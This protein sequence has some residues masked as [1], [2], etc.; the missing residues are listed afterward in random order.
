MSRA[1]RGL[2]WTPGKEE[3]VFLLVEAVVLV[4]GLVVCR[5]YTG[6]DQV[7][8]RA[9]YDVVAGLGPA[10]AWRY[11]LM[12]VS[13]AEPVH[14]LVSVV[15]SNL[16]IDK[17]LWFSLFNC[18][19]AVLMMRLLRAW[20]F[21]LWLAVVLVLTNYYVLVLYFPAERLKFGFLF[22]TV[23]LFPG[24][25]PGWRVALVA[26][27]VLSHLSMLVPVSSIWLVSA[28]RALLAKDERRRRLL[29]V[30]IPALLG[31][32]F[33]L[34]ESDYIFWKLKTYIVD[35]EFDNSWSRFLPIAVM[36]ALSV[37][38]ARDWVQPALMFAPLVGGIAL[39]GG[40][41]LNMFVFFTYLYFARGPRAASDPVLLLLFVYMA[42]KSI[43]FLSNVGAY[44]SGFQ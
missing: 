32:A 43:S 15:G 4:V 17:D 6:G 34:F 23:A 14:F 28:W 24:I 2:L 44:G 21:S 37:F 19:L 26:L 40:S 30:A 42:A 29:L 27:A 16:G 8:Y 3:L 12:H 33:L 13:S 18:L 25:R 7:G 38:Y 1:G 9:A 39:M 22:M 36:L 10:E 11:Y 31:G 5:L 35:V 20:G 41:R